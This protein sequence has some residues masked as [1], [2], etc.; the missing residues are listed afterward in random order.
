MGEEDLG[1]KALVSTR[2]TLNISAIHIK[3]TL[4]NTYAAEALGDFSIQA[5]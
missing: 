3:R 1:Q 4:R 5:Q 2:N